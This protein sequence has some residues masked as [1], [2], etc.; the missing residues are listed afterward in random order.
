M[1]EC[2]YVRHGNDVF[3]TDVVQE[4]NAS[5]KAHAETLMTVSLYNISSVLFSRFKDLSIYII[6]PTFYINYYIV[7]D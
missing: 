2:V 3:L 6:R 7:I 1:Y 4:E 5:L